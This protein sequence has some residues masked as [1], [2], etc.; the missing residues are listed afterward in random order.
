MM[1][2]ASN[3]FGLSELDEQR[4]DEEAEGA[5]LGFLALPSTVPHL[6]FFRAFYEVP[7]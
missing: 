2:S 1:R 4:G 5:R 6:F 3:R 7:S